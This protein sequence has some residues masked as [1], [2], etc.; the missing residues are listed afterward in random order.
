MG[1]RSGWL[2][3]S[4][5]A[6]DYAVGGRS[7]WRGRHIFSP[8]LVACACALQSTCVSTRNSGMPTPTPAS[9]RRLHASR[10]ALR[11]RR[12]DPRTARRRRRRTAMRSTP[13]RRLASCVGRRVARSSS[14]ATAP[15]AASQGG[16]ARNRR[17]ASPPRS[18]RS[19]SRPDRRAPQFRPR[20]R[21]RRR[22]RARRCRLGGGVE[23]GG[24]AAGAAVR[25][26]LRPQRADDARLAQPDPRRGRRA[27][28][29]PPQRLRP[30]LWRGAL[31]PAVREPGH[32]GMR[33]AAC[34]STPTG[35]DA[36]TAAR[37][38]PARRPGPRVVL[39]A[40]STL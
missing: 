7:G 38:P 14:P 19:R 35:G 22:R 26:R 37:R 12:V 8:R 10:L 27:E 28:G 5:S 13:V 32:F 33:V 3:H 31:A 36:A 30:R 1:E 34:P 16:G 24:V 29:R 2:R 9:P 4:F 20:G 23:L 15:H 17:R 25:R 21:G 40:R 18:R 11:A 39:R 6:S